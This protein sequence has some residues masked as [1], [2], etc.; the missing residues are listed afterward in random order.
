MRCIQVRANRFSLGVT[1]G[2]ATG[3]GAGTGAGATPVAGST[4]ARKWRSGELNG[5]GQIVMVGDSGLQ[6]RRCCEPRGLVM[7]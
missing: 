2:T 5:A 1:V 6:V 3:T 4:L 7:V